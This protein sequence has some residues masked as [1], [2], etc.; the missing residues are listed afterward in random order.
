[1]SCVCRVRLRQAGEVQ[2]LEFF[3]FFAA[4]QRSAVP[5]HGKRSL[6]E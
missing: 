2:K 6:S 5:A 4:T 1:M 3:L